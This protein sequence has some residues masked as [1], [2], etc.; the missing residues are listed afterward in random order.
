MDFWPKVI[1]EFQ[2]RSKIR[3]WFAL[4]Y[5]ELQGVEWSV[6]C[7]ATNGIAEYANVDLNKSE[8]K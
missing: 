2:R 5:R 6:E 4:F 1:F 7:G 8:K 3:C